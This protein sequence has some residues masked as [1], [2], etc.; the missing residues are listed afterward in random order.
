M[1]TL[2]ALLSGLG[3]LVGLCGFAFGFAGS[4]FTY[5]AVQVPD[6]VT[7]TVDGNLSDWSWFPEAATLTL[8]DAA[9]AHVCE[10]ANCELHPDDF[11]WTIQVAWR[12]GDDNRIY[13][14]CANYDDV[15]MLPEIV[16]EWGLHK[17][18]CF[19]L[20]VD[21]DNSGGLGGAAADEENIFGRYGQQWYFTPGAPGEGGR[22]EQCYMGAPWTKE[23]DWMDK[24]PFAEAAV[25]WEGNTCYFEGALSLFSYMD[26]TGAE[27]S[28][29]LILDDVF[30][31][32]GA[33][34]LGFLRDEHDVEV[35]VYDAQWKSHS[36]TSSWQTSDEVPDFV[37]LGPPEVTSVEASRWGEIKALLK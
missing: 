7:V 30:A 27:A 35:G 18:D 11:D 16:G 28:T 15:W 23:A 21:P 25:A 36:G 2:A 12:G 13:F 31:A 19:E 33:I 3:L 32:G 24:P 20:V 1:K 9:Y 26:L 10:G 22:L 4:G 29:R 37:L 34:G 14:D 6:G 17:W 5:Y 8:Q